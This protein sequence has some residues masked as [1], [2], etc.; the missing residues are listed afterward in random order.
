MD[1]NTGV[2]GAANCEPALIRAVRAGDSGLVK[3]LLLE[4]SDPAVCDARGEP[5]FCLAVGMRFGAIAQ[6]LLMHGADPG[7]YGPDGPLSLR[8]AVDSGSPALVEVLLDDSVRGRYRESELL[9]MRDLARHWHETGVEPEL[10][11][12][13]GA[14]GAVTRIRVQDDEFTSVDEYSL[15]GITVW[16]GHAAILTRLE[17]LLGIRTSFEELMDRAL[18]Q[19]DQDHA[20]WASATFLLANRRDQETWAAAAELRTRPDASH[21]LFGAEVLRLTHLL[22]DSDEDPFAGPSLDIFADWSADEADLTVLTEVLVAVGEHADPR[23]GAALLPYADHH[24][25]GVRRTVAAGFGAWSSAPAFPRAVHK[26]LLEL[27][28]DPEVVVRQYACLTVA[29][30]KDRDPVFADAMAALLDDADRGVQVV[31]VYGLARHDDERCVEGSRRLGPP[32]PRY[33]D[34]ELYLDAVW[35]YE[36]RRDGR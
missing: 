13:M 11:G 28:S 27:M 29:N 32:Q 25:A 8:E 12:R 36:W 5:A 35:R 3:R 7:L 6:L 24:D 22:D 21:R 34:E 2:S 9:E 1:A 17:E 16:D 19:P 33:P 26:A 18:S 10:R 23:A 20:G 14:R 15:G 30:G 4:G 31:A